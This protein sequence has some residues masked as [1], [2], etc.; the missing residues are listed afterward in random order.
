M[1]V[2]LDAVVRPPAVIPAASEAALAV[3]ETVVRLLRGPVLGALDVDVV[4]LMGRRFGGHEAGEQ[5]APVA[6]GNHD[7]D[8]R[9]D[10]EQA[11][12]RHVTPPFS[13]STTHTQNPTPF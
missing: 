11:S 2:R 6:D 3:P 1:P 4:R 5:V 10:V 12:A 8:E 13:V 7:A 9:D